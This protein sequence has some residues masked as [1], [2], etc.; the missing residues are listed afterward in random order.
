MVITIRPVSFLDIED[1]ARLADDMDIARM[2]A[3]MPSPY[4]RKDAQNWVE[5]LSTRP[6]KHAFAICGDGL[7][8]VVGLICDPEHDRAELGY[9]LGRPFW[10]K[11]ATTAAVR[12]AVDYAFLELKVRRVY[13]YCFAGNIASRRVLEKNGL[14]YEGCLKQHTVRMGTVHDL[15]CFGLL[16]EDYLGKDTKTHNEDL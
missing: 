12:L 3:C 8:G 2:T 5:G 14:F 11:G 6:N 15:L 16:K 4:T 9:W 1:I 13:A 10:G 7:M